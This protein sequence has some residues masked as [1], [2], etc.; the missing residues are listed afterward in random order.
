M[1]ILSYL[2]KGA[3]LTTKHND[4]VN[5]MTISWGNIG[6]EWNEDVFITMV[7]DSRFT[8]T[9]LDKTGEFSVTIPLDDS[10]KKELAFCGSRSGRDVDKIEECGFELTDGKSIDVPAIK[11]HSLVIEC[12]VLYAQRMEEAIMTPEFKEKFYSSGDIHTLY[13]GKITQIY[14]V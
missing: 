2:K 14:E 7:R 12:K 9:A 5:T 10:M 13:H 4:K 6:I 1:D 11:C 3:F 8:K